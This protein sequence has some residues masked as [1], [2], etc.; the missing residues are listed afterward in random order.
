MT[1]FLEATN[2]IAAC[3]YI[4]IVVLVIAELRRLSIGFPPVVV[5]LVVYF[6]V[7][8]VDLL[9]APDPILGYSPRFDAVTDVAVIMLLLYLLAHAR[10]IARLAL[11]TI[12]EAQVR[13]AEYERARHDYA[14]MVHSKIAGPLSV[15][16][17]A[18]QSLR[19]VDDPKGREELEKLIS[20][21]SATL[22]QVSEELSQ[23][24]DQSRQA[25][26]RPIDDQ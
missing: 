3:I 8:V 19:V 24:R 13:L 10:R 25:S 22:R 26:A 14:V 1:T 4:V 9:A 15:I 12:N 20:D 17:G 2:I 6:A 16:S 11:L 21:S 23:V 18:A 5:A 7:R